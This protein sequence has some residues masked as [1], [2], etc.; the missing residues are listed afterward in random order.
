MVAGCAVIIAILLLAYDLA[1]GGVTLRYR[2]TVD[3]DVN[4]VTHTG[5][6]VVQVTYQS[7]P[8]WFI[9]ALPLD[10]AAQFHGSL[11]GS[12]ITVDLGKPGLLFVV[13]FTPLLGGPGGYYLPHGT[14]LDLLPFVAYRS[15]FPPDAQAFP[16]SGPSWVILDRARLIRGAKAKPINI[17]AENL[18]LLVRFTNI[19]DRNSIEQVDPRDLAAAYG[20]G[21][22][23]VGATFELTRDPVSPMPSVWPS[24]LKLDKGNSF[25][26]EDKIVWSFVANN[27][28]AFKGDAP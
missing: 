9:E 11:T 25:K 23:L 16:E 21:V 17:P 22:R 10:W 28:A 13:N 7:L 4:G 27:I 20:A 6:G 8:Q 24:W 26:V 5:S 3:V 15:L 18:P 12:A 2:L 14:S 19:N 1:G